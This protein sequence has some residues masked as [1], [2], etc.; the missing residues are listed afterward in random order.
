MKVQL[1]YGAELF[2]ALV[3][4]SG[5]DGTVGRFT[6]HRLLLR[7]GVV[8]IDALSGTHVSELLRHLR[9]ELRRYLSDEGEYEAAI[10]RLEELDQSFS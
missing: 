7:V 8:E 6:I 5:L 4:A 2:T 3:R 9:L 1:A 10:R